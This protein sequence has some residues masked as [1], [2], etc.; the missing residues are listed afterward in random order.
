MKGPEVDAVQDA[1]AKATLMGLA[2]NKA[3]QVGPS[4]IRDIVGDTLT[5]MKRCP[6]HIDT[7][8]PAT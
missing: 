2:A 1:V 4:H 8:A 7:H 6:T 5:C 3:Q